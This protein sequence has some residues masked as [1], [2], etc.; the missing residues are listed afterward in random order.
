MMMGIELSCIF[1][2]SEGYI[3]RYENEHMKLMAWLELGIVHSL[4]V[5]V[6]S[7]YFVHPWEINGSMYKSMTPLLIPSFPLDL[8][9]NPVYI[10]NK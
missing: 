6:D 5:Y 7:K 8:N 2:L 4:Y 10:D 1:G 9:T 3:E